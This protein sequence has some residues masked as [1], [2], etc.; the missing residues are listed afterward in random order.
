MGRR[1]RPGWT[2]RNGLVVKKKSK[3]IN[4]LKL[5]LIGLVLCQLICISEIIHLAKMVA[6]HHEALSEI[7]NF[8][9]NL[10]GQR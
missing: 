8:L 5:V 9:M 6:M 7:I 10:T 1:C 3:R 4:K 2:L